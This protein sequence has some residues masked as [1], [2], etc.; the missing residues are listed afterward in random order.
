[1]NYSII[2]NPTELNNFIAWLP[3]LEPHETYYVC[4]F[5]RSKYCT[6]ISHIRSDKVQLKRFTTNKERL[7]Q[8]LQQLE[9]AEGTYFQRDVPIPQE[10]LAAYITPNPRDMEKAAKAS[11]IKLANLITQPYNGYNPHQEIMSE[12]QKS[13]SRRVYIDF[14]FDNTLKVDRDVFNKQIKDKVLERINPE[15]VNFLVTRGGLHLMIKSSEVDPKYSKTWYKSLSAMIGVD[16]IS[17]IS[18]IPIP[19]CV[20]GDTYPTLYTDALTFLK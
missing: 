19:G 2:K 14:D 3:D 16:Q 18:M 9:C 10:G 8:K 11:L 13:V 5:V 1:M 4:L 17:S 12:I 7:F 15:C 6:G 20:Q